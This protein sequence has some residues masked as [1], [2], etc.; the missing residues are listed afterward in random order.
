[1]RQ[2]YADDQVT[3]YCGDC[4]EIVPELGRFDLVAIDPPYGK[5]RGHF[6]EE[7]TNRPA[8]LKDSAAW[9]DL[10][11]DAM[12]PNGT[13][14]WFAWPSLA[15]RIEAQ[16]AERLNP[17]AHIVWIKPSPH[18]QKHCPELLRAPGPETERILMAE[19]YGADNMA[20]GESGYARKCDE[21]RG[22]VFEPIRAYLAGERD[23]AGFDNATINDAW[24]KWKGVSC[25]SQTQKWFSNSCFNPPTAE[26]YAWLQRLFNGETGTDYLRKE[27]EDLRKDYEDLRKDY[28][29]LRKEYEDLRQYFDMHT[30]DQKTDVWR[31]AASGNRHGH[32]TEK[33]LDLMQ[34]IVR[35]SCRPGGTV[36]DF[37]GGSGTTAVAAKSLGRKCVLVEREERYC[38]IA[39]NRCK[40]EYLP[41]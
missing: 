39:A 34:Y 25:T 20:L 9:R 30:G 28:E 38:E 26:A 23:R 41:I 13:L 36:L 1:M 15:G 19:H 5:V 18:A 27:Y 31:F 10:A 8:M 29:D 35:L 3:I 11:V 6:D 16:I 37:F 12:K 32:P 40:Q 24:C 7:W 14:Y 21:A 33:P 17:L 4:R 2:Y 22:F